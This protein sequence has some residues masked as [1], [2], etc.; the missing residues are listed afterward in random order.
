MERGTNKE[1]ARSAFH[2]LLRS[3]FWIL[4]KPSRAF[5]A[6]IIV[7]RINLLIIL[8]SKIN[9]RSRRSRNIYMFF[10]RANTS[11]ERQLLV[12][13]ARSKCFGRLL[14]S[15]FR[16]C[17]ILMYFDLIP[18]L[19][20][21]AVIVTHFDGHSPNLFVLNK[22]FFSVST[23]GCGVFFRC[24]HFDLQYAAF[25][26]KPFHEKKVYVHRHFVMNI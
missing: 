26:M 20:C 1:L 16:S 25:L 14:R 12:S 17:I 5:T 6:I 7:S 21:M 9:R 13:P 18:F 24:S 10:R 8:Y 3:R 2:V 15:E 19:V 23:G 4:K 22:S 11:R